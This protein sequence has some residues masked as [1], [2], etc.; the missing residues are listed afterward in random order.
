MR[1][2]RSIA[3]RVATIQLVLM[4]AII[5]LLGTAEAAS[6]SIFSDAPRALGDKLGVS[7]Y[8][9]GMILACGI[10][11]S[12]A[13]ALAVLRMQFAGT[14]ITLLAV[15]V[16]LAAVGWLDKLVVIFAAIVVAIYFGLTMR[17]I[18]GPSTE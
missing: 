7:D 13:L 11:I 8:V 16:L 5:A 18:W 15:M 2:N 3:Q 1:A 6:A 14:V 10:I 17:G 4:L 9:A 12:L